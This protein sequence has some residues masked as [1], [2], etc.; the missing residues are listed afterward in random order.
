MRFIAAVEYI[1]VLILLVFLGACQENKQ[2]EIVANPPPAMP[3]AKIPKKGS[4][5]FPVTEYVPLNQ[6]IPLE[7]NLDTFGFYRGVVILPHFV[8]F[9]HDVLP[10]TFKLKSRK[11]V[12]QVSFDISGTGSKKPLF[13]TTLTPEGEEEGWVLYTHH[14]DSRTLDTNNWP[15]ELIARFFLKEGMGSV[16][17]FQYVQAEAVLS[18]IEPGRYVDERLVFPTQFLKMGFFIDY[19]FV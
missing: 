4:N 6:W 13:E 14:L 1:F 9:K 8:H 2:V 18:E 17:T 5:T 19:L 10:I 7:R 16:A 11:S 3:V 12:A 15:N